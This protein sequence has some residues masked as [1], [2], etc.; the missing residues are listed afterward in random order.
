I[1]LDAC[2]YLHNYEILPNDALVARKFSDVLARYPVFGSEAVDGLKDYLRDRVINGQGQ[3]VL[4]RIEQSK[5]RPSR[6]L[7]D[8]VA[9]TGSHCTISSRLLLELVKA[10]SRRHVGR[11]HRHRRMAQ[12]LECAA[13]CRP[14]SEG[15]TPADLW[16]TEAGGIEQVGCIYT[17]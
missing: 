12:T 8:Y 7:M 14:V 13:Q 5:Y 11:R 4:T 1:C 3:D 16:A 9:D 15:H 10:Q 17:A 6:K 2:S